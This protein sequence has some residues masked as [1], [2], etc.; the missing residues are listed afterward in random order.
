MYCYAHHM[1]VHMYILLVLGIESRTSHML[2][3]HPATEIHP[4]A[5]LSP[6]CEIT[7]PLP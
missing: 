6:A 2:I 3:K 1:C 7:I 5:L 4:L